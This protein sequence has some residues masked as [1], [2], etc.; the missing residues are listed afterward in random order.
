MQKFINKFKTR[1]N[2]DHSWQIGLILLLCSISGLS[3]LYVRS[4]TVAWLGF[5]AQTALWEQAVV[6][7]VVVVPAYQAL[8]LLF[9]SLFGQFEFAWEFQKNNF[10]KVK[11]LVKTVF[12]NGPSLH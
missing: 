11:K 12:I 1:W 8:F 7:L 2:I 5:T 10:R 3:V 4:V 6:W 9:G